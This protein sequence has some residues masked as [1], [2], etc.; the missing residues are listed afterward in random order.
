VRR[1]RQEGQKELVSRIVRLTPDG[2]ETEP[3]S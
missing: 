1:V 3:S 2:K